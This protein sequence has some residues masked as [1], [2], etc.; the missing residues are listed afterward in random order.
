MSSRSRPRRE[1][2]G[3]AASDAILQNRI[4]S[5]RGPHE[6]PKSPSKAPTS[7]EATIL[8]SGA[9]RRRFRLTREQ[10]AEIVDTFNVVLQE[11]TSLEGMTLVFDPDIVKVTEWEIHP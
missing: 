4:H 8:G 6:L 5:S 10:V 2:L 7:P 3:A 9:Q 1:V 11:D